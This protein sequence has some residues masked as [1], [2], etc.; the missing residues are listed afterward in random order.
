MNANTQSRRGFTLV[1]LLVV[2]AI[3]GILI[4]LLLPA[5]QAAREAA[6]RMQCTNNLKQFGL[7]FQNYHDANNALMAGTNGANGFT[8][9]YKVL[10]YIEQASLY[11][12]IDWNPPTYA[13][14]ANNSAVFNAKNRISMFS[15][16]SDNPQAYVPDSD[17]TST[18]RGRYLGN[19]LVSVGSTAWYDTI[20][21]ER[22][23]NWWVDELDVNGYAKHHGAFFGGHYQSGSHGTY[24]NWACAVDG[25]SNTAIM[26]ELLIGE[27][28]PT[29]PGGNAR[30]DTRGV[31]WRACL[32]PFYTHYNTPNSSYP[33][34]MLYDYCRCV[35]NEKLGRPCKDYKYEIVDNGGVAEDV[36]WVSARSR[37]S[38]GVNC[39]YADG[40]VHFISDTINVDVWRALGSTQGGETTVT[41]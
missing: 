3:I 19:Y 41:P 33:D 30:Q 6:R 25:T 29:S 31:F 40:S 18:Y 34:K 22:G 1:E 4:G 28:A 32:T 13:G 23:V 26:S 11:Q 36:A 16:P 37:H 9:A 24:Q 20:G 38:G 15:C 5:V 10:P 2:I 8:W 12:T 21:T 39:V 14:T 17:P 27:F 35:N 7:A